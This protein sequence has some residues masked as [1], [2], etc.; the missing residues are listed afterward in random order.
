M[1]LKD[2]WIDK[3][4]TTTGLDGDDIL[5]EDINAIANEVIKQGEK[6]EKIPDELNK[7][8]NVEKGKG[9]S[10]NDFT[11]EYKEKLDNINDEL[12]QNDWNQNDETKADYIK[13]RT[14]YTTYNEETS[15]KMV[16][17]MAGDKEDKHIEQWGLIADNTYSVTLRLWQ[18]G[19]SLQ[20]Y[21]F[22]AQAV[23]AFDGN[24]WLQSDESFEEAS[25]F[26][27]DI[28]NQNQ[29]FIGYPTF[30]D[31]F[32]RAQLTVQGTFTNPVVYRI[33]V[34]YIEDLQKFNFNEDF[35][36]K[37]LANKN[38][39]NDVYERI[40]EL[41]D[42]IGGS[43]GGADWNQNDETALDYIK[44]R[45]HY[46]SKVLVAEFI[47]AQPWENKTL[48]E[49]IDFENEYI[50]NINGTD[51]ETVKEGT[52]ADFF[53]K[54]DGHPVFQGWCNETE[55]TIT[56]Y[57]EYEGQNVSLYKISVKKLDD[58]YIPD[59]IARVADVENSKLKNT[60]SGDAM[61][62]TD[63]A[64]GKAHILNVYG[65]TTQN[66]TPTPNAP[67]EL[68]SVGESVEVSVYDGK[69]LIPYPYNPS[70]ALTQNGI[71]LAIN[72]D[73]SIVANGTATTNT[74]F[75]FYHYLQS[76]ISISLLPN[77]EYTLSGCVGGSSTTYELRVSDNKTTACI[78]TN[79]GTVFSYADTS[80]ITVS[81]LVRSGAVLNN[82]VFKPQIEVGSATPYTPYKAPTTYTVQT[83][84][85]LRGIKVTSGGNY[86][87]S[88]GQRWICDEIDYNRG[89]YIQRIGEYRNTGAPMACYTTVPNAEKDCIYWND[90][91]RG[92]KLKQG[93]AESNCFTY[94]WGYASIP[95]I[96]GVAN[97]GGNSYLYFSIKLSDTEYG[98]TYAT[99]KEAVNAWV[100]KTFTE[101]NPLI[102][103]YALETPIE[104][105]L[106]AEMIEAYTHYPTTTILSDKAGLKIGYVADT[107]NYI[108]NKFAQLETALLSIAD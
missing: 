107:K 16:N 100:K 35:L 77:T 46:D 51:V 36:N 12:V 101:D 61:K 108:D 78:S 60:A 104:T 90:I 31:E 20:T 94:G 14:H 19:G 54:Y 7:K 81:I 63:S 70:M 75:F 72:E 45:T 79:K 50:I 65:K 67:I 38:D 92:I 21:N 52:S 9:L 44:N 37:Y 27:K 85:G 13:N 86:T 98:T 26:I 25:F 73:G 99:T 93:Y 56:V 66:G 22:E 17:W 6:L 62:L 71:T 3:K 33:P 48:P 55:N 96:V 4:D 47:N 58:K 103:Y 41:E 87:D 23:A 80:Q 91:L 30:F 8:V 105:P 57:P 49:P 95:Y 28:P 5:A 42:S 34:K 76:T 29:T 24:V 18:R 32:G 83:P 102:V 59:S 68:E 89:V 82:V 40:N 15:T 106:T 88:N 11:D 74:Q 64:D 53:F 43:L 39:I 10:S 69:N 97:D 84:N 1:S 2:T